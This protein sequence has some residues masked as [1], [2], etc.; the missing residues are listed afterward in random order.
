MGIIC[1]RFIVDHEGKVFRL[2][3]TTF[4]RLMRDPLH[5]T[6]PA[7]AGQRMRMAEILVELANRVPLRVYFVV[8]FDLAGRLDTE[9]LKRQHRAL[10]EST[11]DHALAA[12][13]DDD[14]VLDATSRFADSRVRRDKHATSFGESSHATSLAQL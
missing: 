1:R 13:S 6:M 8:N 2:K 4:E 5:H 12:P 9:R 7:L 10:A 14:R 11:L 3:S